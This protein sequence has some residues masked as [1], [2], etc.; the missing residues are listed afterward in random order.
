MTIER[1]DG[2]HDGFVIEGP[3]VRRVVHRMG[4]FRRIIHWANV[5]AIVIAVITGMYIADPY[6]SSG[7]THVMSV[8]R[9]LHFYAAVV[10][11]VTVVVTAYLYVFSREERSILDLIPNASNRQ[12]LTAAVLNVVTFNR[13]RDL[14]TTRPDPLNALMFVALH[15]FA[16][17]QLFTGFQ[18]Y[19]QGLEA[20]MSSIGPWWPWLIH[21]T[22]DWT[23]PVFGGLGGIRLVHHAMTYP[24]TIWVMLHVYYEVW[25][26]VVWKEA[27][28]TITIA[29]YKLARERQ[30]HP[31]LRRH[32]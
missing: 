6:Y 5:V 16:I 32:R 20:G 14:D 12:R 23:Q 3:T 24:I 28:I 22:T 29:G 10:L 31:S 21:T 2:A 18:M 13:R 25:R 4:I 8:N 30:P 26:T 17:F 7:I 11:D 19:V 27:D 15:L 9:T 1:A